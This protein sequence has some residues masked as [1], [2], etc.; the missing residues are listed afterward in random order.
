MVLVVGPLLAIAFYIRR[1]E[2][3]TALVLLVVA[4]ALA[5]FL[6]GRVVEAAS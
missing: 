4:I 1:D 3:R 6:V 5:A 2:P